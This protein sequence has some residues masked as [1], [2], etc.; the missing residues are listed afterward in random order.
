MKAN[1]DFKLSYFL[2]G[3]GLGAI[4]GLLFAPCEEMYLREHH[5]KRLNKQAGKLR[6][7][8]EPLVKRRT[9]MSRADSV[10]T[11]TEAEK[12]AYQEERRETLGG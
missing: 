8:A 2:I 1:F 6:R 4:A 3:I 9:F 12:Q 10:V 11:D 7:S 5:N